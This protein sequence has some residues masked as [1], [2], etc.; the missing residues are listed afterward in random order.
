MNLY[1]DGNKEKV[2]DYFERIKKEGYYPDAS[3]QGIKI[4]DIENFL[5]IIDRHS[6]DRRDVIR[7]LLNTKLPSL[8]SKISRTNSIADGASVAH[9]GAY[10]GILLRGKKK[11]DRE[12]RDYWIKP[13]VD[14]GILEPITLQ[15][16]KFTYGHIK[17]KSPNSAYR[18]NQEFVALL[19]KTNALNSNESDNLIK[20]W[21]SSADERKRLIV[22]Y[23]KNELEISNS[24]HGGLINDSVN[25]YARNYLDSYI[26]LFKDDTDGDRITAEESVMLN[27]YG[28]KLGGL[29]DVWPDAILYNEE[30]K[31]LWFIEAVTSDGE[32]NNHKLKGFKTIC[33]NSNKIFGGCTTTYYTWKRF[34]ERQ[35][36][37]NNL[38]VE[39]FV[40]IKESPEKY[41]SVN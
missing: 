36:A 38:A 26:C 25:I 4:K 12:G 28:I 2:D 23:E 17:P 7:C 34:Y 41:F 5:K 21:F 33:A 35:S 30:K 14:I 19:K 1:K 10:I 37:T 16:E 18:L 6:N 29:R 3:F 20:E 13:L 8:F 27:K 39:S 9:I 15:G 11:L 40:W 31:S 24:S 22:T 32:I